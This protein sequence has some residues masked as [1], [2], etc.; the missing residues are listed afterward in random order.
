[1]THSVRFPAYQA[2][3]SDSSSSVAQAP[4][5]AGRCGQHG[6]GVGG[7]GGR[8]G[9][10]CVVPVDQQLLGAVGGPLV[11]DG[12]ADDEAQ[13]L[14]QQRAVAL[15]EVGHGLRVGDALGVDPVEDLLGA[16]FWQAPVFE[17]GGE[18]LGGVVEE[19]GAGRH[20]G[21]VYSG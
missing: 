2:D 10:V 18:A 6:Q 19:V 20:G 17:E 13:V 16:V 1:M 8:G 14:L 3:S 4:P 5:E 7:I 12:A 21:R 9:G 11:A 15:A